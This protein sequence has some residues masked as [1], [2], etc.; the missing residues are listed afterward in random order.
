MSSDVPS[1]ARKLGRF[2]A[3]VIL[4]SAGLKNGEKAPT[5]CGLSDARRTG[6]PVLTT[7]SPPSIARRWLASIGIGWADAT[8]LKPPPIEAYRLPPSAAQVRPS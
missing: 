3:G 8:L 2:N 7:M 4:S 1:A 5:R 6:P